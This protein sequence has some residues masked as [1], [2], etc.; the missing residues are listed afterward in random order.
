[1]RTVYCGLV[2][3]KYIGQTVT[4]YVQ[5]YLDITPISFNSNDNV[6]TLDIT[7]MIQIVASTADKAED[8]VTEEKAT[9]DNPQNA[10]IYKEAKALDMEGQNV[11]VVLKLPSTFTIPVDT[12]VAYVLH[13][14]E[15]GEQYVY[16]GTVSDERSTFTFTNPNGFSE[17]TVYADDPSAARVSRSA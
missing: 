5:T 11:T 1:M 6:L 15:N 12:S 3:E 10:V 2:D 16:T 17:F 14:K 13:A 9:E 7:P 4:L 8:I